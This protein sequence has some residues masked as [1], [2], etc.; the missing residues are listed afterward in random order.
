MIDQ[1]MVDKHV[2]ELQRQLESKN[3]SVFSW[4]QAWNTYA[5]TFFSTNFG[6][7][8]N[9]FGREHVADILTTMNRVQKQIFRDSNIATYL[10]GTLKERFSIDDIPDGFLYFPASLGGLDLQNPFIPLLQVRNSVFA[11][12]SSIIDHFLDAEREA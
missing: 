12:P 5:G 4:V 6:K 7:P 10:K 2:L 3:K 1:D 9:C 8:A 11:D